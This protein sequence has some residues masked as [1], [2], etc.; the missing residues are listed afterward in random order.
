MSE[1]LKVESLAKHYEI[2]KSVV[3]AVDGVSFTIG[4][5]ESLGLVGESGCGKSTVG[6]SILRLIEPSA[7]QVVFD[8]EDVLGK[9]PREMR[10][11][12]RDMQIIFQDPFSALNPR[13]TVAQAIEEP[14]II[15][16]RSSRAERRA[17]VDEALRLVGLRPEHRDRFPHEFSGGQRQRI[18]IARALVL[19]PR[20]VVADEAV[21]ALD[22]SVQAQILNLLHDLQ[23]RL[24]L[25]MLF[26]SHDLGVIRYVC[27]R[28][29]V[30][31][32]GRIVEIG[33]VEDVIR[34]P[35]HPYSRLL[36]SAVPKL[37]PRQRSRRSTVAGELPSP[38]DPPGGCPFHTRCPHRMPVCDQI[39]PSMSGAAPDRSVACHLFG[40]SPAVSPAVS[41]KGKSDEPAGHHNQGEPQ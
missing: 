10:D 2:G 6:R 33:T 24:G 35:L 22:V 3:R 41:L 11:L 20:F 9:S 15:H 14:I 28:V 13:L 12:R 16:G 5:R 17:K 31:Y 21:S 34:E 38:L 23:E 25:S 30:M 40:G 37:D 4:A 29:A 8:G 36:L 32:L 27:Q 39:A 18:G 26:I 1:L 7:G 19:D